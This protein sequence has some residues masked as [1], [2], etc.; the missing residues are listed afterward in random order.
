M[1]RHQDQPAINLT[2]KWW[3]FTAGMLEHASPNETLWLFFADFSDPSCARPAGCLFFDNGELIRPGQDS[4]H[5]YGHATKLH[6]VK[7]LSET[8]YQESLMVNISPDQ[9]PGSSGIHTFNQNAEFRV[10]DCKFL[11]SRFNFAFLSH[12]FTGLEAKSGVSHSPRTP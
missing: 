12:V 11:I 9:I 3:L 5:G 2:L 4:T 6:R 1:S 7:V 10:I 8:D